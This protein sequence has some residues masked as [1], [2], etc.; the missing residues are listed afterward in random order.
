MTR[1]TVGPDGQLT[2]PPTDQAQYGWQPGAAVRVVE[3]RGGVL[4]VSPCLVSK[5]VSFPHAP[6]LVAGN[7]ATGR[8]R[9]AARVKSP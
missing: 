2:L 3:T 8:R 9:H 6:Y 4:L 1:M 7:I 5:R